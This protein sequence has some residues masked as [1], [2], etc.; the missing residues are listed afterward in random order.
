MVDCWCSLYFKFSCTVSMGAID[1]NCLK[2]LSH[3][4]L[5]STCASGVFFFMCT[6]KWRRPRCVCAVEWI[7]NNWFIYCWSKL[8]SAFLHNARNWVKS[9]FLTCQQ[10]ERDHVDSLFPT[11]SHLLL[12]MDC[13]FSDLSPFLLLGGWWLTL[14]INA[15]CSFL[16]SISYSRKV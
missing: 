3:T 15:P 10:R 6:D 9:F 14:A 1:R 13:I 16:P 4:L 5:P 7:C 11:S 2:G 12:M 8:V